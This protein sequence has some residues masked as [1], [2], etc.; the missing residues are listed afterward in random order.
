M[1]KKLPDIKQDFAQWYQEI[2]Y[3]AE[4]ADTSP[5]KGCMVIRPYGNS[6][7][8]NIK[9]VLDAKI[10]ETGHQNALFPL[11]I[12]QKFLTKEAEHVEGFSPELAVVTHAGGK[13][14]EEPLVIRPTSETIIHYMF[15]KWIHSWRDLPL[16]I[17]QWGNVVR[18]EMRTRPF[19]RTTEIFWQEGHTAH[20]TAEEAAEEADLMLQEYKK[21]AEDY[22][23]IPVVAGQKSESEKFPGADKTMSIEGMMPDGK[24]LQMGTSHI[25]SQNFA[26]VFEMTYQDRKGSMV[27][28][29]LTSW[30][31][32][33][34]VVGAV[35]MAHG[36]EKGLIIPPKVAPIHAVVVPILKKD[37]D[38]K[39]VLE[40]A[41]AIKDALKKDFSIVVDDD[42]SKSPGAKFYKWE[43]KGV[44]LRI[45]IGPRDLESG[46]AVV[47][48]RLGLEKKA[49]LLSEL[50]QYIVDQLDLI[51]KTLFERA[52][53]R[54]KD[55]W[56]VR[57]KFSEFKDDLVKQGGFYQ[58]GWCGS[59]EC[60]KALKESQATIRCLLEEK[61]VTDCFYC[62]KKSECDVLVAKAY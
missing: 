22:L 62:D 29:F 24:A 34:R 28:P 44:P 35:V 41:V 27:Y 31:M 25:I 17:N 49:V 11:L 45:E 51:Q 9:S 3:Q 37:A 42:D 13:E 10:K 54:L 1:A 32:S 30:G 20:E 19:L 2:V 53:K 50:P 4:L 8:E 46:Q 47:V 36:D 15:A 33:T 55:Q 7:W 58:V 40:A 21:L 57:N 39:A 38:N 48:D 43:L 16:K 56:C 26:K 59:V 12:P 14:L 23:A 6:L 60:E 61:K 5:V 52:E 18:W